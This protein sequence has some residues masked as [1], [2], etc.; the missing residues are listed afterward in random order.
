MWGGMRGGEG[1]GQGGR[2]E[3]FTLLP[4]ALQGGRAGVSKNTGVGSGMGG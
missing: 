2:G 4:P 3:G 1:G